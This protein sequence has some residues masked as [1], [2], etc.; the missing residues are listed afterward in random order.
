MTTETTLVLRWF[1]IAWTLFAA[2]EPLEPVRDALRVQM[3]LDV[4]EVVIDDDVLME[5]VR[6]SGKA[7][8]GRAVADGVAL[9]SARRSACWKLSGPQR[10]AEGRARIAAR[11]RIQRCLGGRFAAGGATCLTAGVAFGL[12]A[13]S[14][15]AEPQL[16]HW[17]L[18]RLPCCWDVSLTDD[19]EQDGQ[20]VPIGM[21]SNSIRSLR[22]IV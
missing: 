17:K 2:G 13:R 5:V 14:R 18:S 12:L 1:G 9:E 4:A 10:P 16:L 6:R 19:D 8:R 15:H 21:A 11:P 20:R 7:L 22:S 3:E